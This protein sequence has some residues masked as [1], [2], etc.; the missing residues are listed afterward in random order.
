MQI[1]RIYSNNTRVFSPIDFNFGETANRLNV[2]YGEV[3]HPRD[4]KKDSHNLGKTTLI[5]L[6]DFLMLRGTS[7]EQFLV[8]HAERFK[9][10]VFFIEIALNAGGYATIRRSAAEPNKIALKRYAARELDLSEVSGDAWDHVD[11][12][13][14]DA[15]K[16]VDGWLDLKI[17][18]PYDYRQA[19]TYFLRTQGDYGDELQL[20][21]F[22]SG[23]DRHWKPFVAHLFGFNEAP[24]EQKYV[25]DEEIERLKQK[26]A[27]QQTTVQF[28]EDQLSELQARI[29]VLQQQVDEIEAGLD[30]FSFEPEERRILRDVVETIEREI[31]EINDRLYNIRYD[32]RQIDTALEHKDK[33]DLAEVTEVFEETR[34]N[35]PTALKRSYEE[36]VAFNK[37]VTQERNVALRGRRKELAQED[38]QLLRRKIELDQNREGQLGVLR[39]TDTFAKFKELQKDLSRQ[40]AQLV[41]FEEQ[42]KLLEQVAETARAV[43]ESERARGRVVDEIKAM[44]ARPTPVFERF[45]AVFNSYC[46]RVLN[47]DGIFFFRVN[48][49]NNFDYQIGLQLIGQAAATS[50]LSEGTSYKKLVCALFD[51][52][53]LKVYEDSPFFHFVYH[54]GIFEALDDR[55]KIALLSIIREQVASK[56]TQ[57]ILTLIDSDMPRDADGNRVE[58]G[59]DEI[60]LRLHDDG[61]DGRLFKMSEF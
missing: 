9:D 11:M 45:S 37:K 25:L 58:F 44:V 50:S 19:I 52:A 57:Y 21:K 26:Q 13:R 18:K 36:L 40:R 34:V 51:L 49:N 33:F 29:G 2:V 24:V 6:I 47:H 55:K 17:L 5:H 61:N 48:A 41:Y 20:A 56:K 43:R 59:P 38:A 7:P 60:V 3:H 1:S 35:F 30:A 8:K 15:S 42:R 28:S 39:S 22:A 54:D 14:D 27:D 23:K 31:A 53:L 4:Q 10:F 16:L 32:A 46:Q 12:S